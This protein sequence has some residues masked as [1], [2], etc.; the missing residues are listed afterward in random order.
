VAEITAMVRGLSGEAAK[1]LRAEVEAGRLEAP[2]PAGR[3]GE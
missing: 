3:P 1:A 2:S